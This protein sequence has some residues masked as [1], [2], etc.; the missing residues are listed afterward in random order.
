VKQWLNSH[1]PL[2][3]TGSE[4]DQAWAFFREDVNQCQALLNRPLSLWS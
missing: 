1:Q 4:R 3:L 2:T